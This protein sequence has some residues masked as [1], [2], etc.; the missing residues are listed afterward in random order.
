MPQQLLNFLRISQDKFGIALHGD[1]DI[2]TLCVTDLVTKWW[3]SFIPSH[4]TPEGLVLQGTA[5]TLLRFISR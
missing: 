5:E 2:R 1:L 3:D 4:M